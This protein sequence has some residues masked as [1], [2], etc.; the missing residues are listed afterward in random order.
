MSIRVSASAEK[1]SQISTPQQVLDTTNDQKPEQAVIENKPSEKYEEKGFFLLLSS[2]LVVLASSIVG[3][4]SLAKESKLGLWISG[5]LGLVSL[6]LAG[7]GAWK[8]TD[9]KPSKLFK[10]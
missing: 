4:I 5:A 10:V 9:G 3:L 6:G 1:G 8:A 7:S 2:L